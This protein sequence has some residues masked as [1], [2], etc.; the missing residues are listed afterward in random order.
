[1]CLFEMIFRSFCYNDIFHCTYGA[2]VPD[3]VTGTCPGNL[4][5][6]GI[7]CHGNM[8]KSGFL[9][10]GQPVPGG[11]MI[12]YLPQKRFG[13]EMRGNESGNHSRTMVS[14]EQIL[15]KTVF[16]GVLYGVIGYSLMG[17]SPL[18]LSPDHPGMRDQT[19]DI[20]IEPDSTRIKHITG[21]QFKF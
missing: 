11:P 5:F 12:S 7:C 21:K 18:F 17:R 1:M 14:W 4:G 20:R 6:Q 8:G 16:G 2:G 13:N 10:I 15:F 9:C 3:N 19:P